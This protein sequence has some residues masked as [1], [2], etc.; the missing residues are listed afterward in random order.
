M[1]A[2][3]ADP[4][5]PRGVLHRTEEHAASIRG[6]ADLVEECAG[7]APAIAAADYFGATLTYAAL[8]RWSNR[9]ANALR[10][11]GAQQNDVI[12]LHLPNTPQYLIGLVAAAKLGCAVTGISPLLTAAEVR[13]QIND[14]GLCVAHRRYRDGNT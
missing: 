4:Y 9:L 1:E 14:A 2:I 5:P 3:H 7:A 10:T 13:H 12:G 11:R 8:D 6:L